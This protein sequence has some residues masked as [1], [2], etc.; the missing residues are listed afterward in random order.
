MLVDYEEN[1]RARCEGMGSGARRRGGDRQGRSPGRRAAWSVV[2]G[3]DRAARLEA[4]GSMWDLPTTSSSRSWCL[5][6]ATAGS[7]T[8]PARRPRCAAAATSGS[9]S[10]LPSTC[11][12]WSWPPTTSGWPTVAG[13]AHPCLGQPVR[14]AA[15][16]YRAPPGRGRVLVAAGLGAD[17][18]WSARP[19][20]LDPVPLGRP[21]PPPPMT[22]AGAGLAVRPW[23]KA[24][25]ADCCPPPADRAP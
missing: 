24:S 14:Q 18:G 4:A 21:S 1:R 25:L 15:L 11:T 19:P 12:C 10:G 3:G 7:P 23:P 5:A 17:R 20:R 13:R 6:A 9:R 2:P 8:T 16:V 22:P